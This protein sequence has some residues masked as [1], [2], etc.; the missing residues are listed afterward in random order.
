MWHFRK[1]SKGEDSVDPIHGEFFASEEIGGL[2]EILVR[3]SIQNSLDARVDKHQG[4]AKVII[5]YKHS[6]HTFEDL[7]GDGMPFAGLDTHVKSS[8]SGL[9]HE[10]LPK[11]E[12]IVDYLVIEDFGTRGLNGDPGYND[13]ERPVELDELGTY[14]FFFFWRN[15]GRSGKTDG[16]GSWGLGKHVFP[17][18]SRINSYFGLTRRTN[19]DAC[20]LMG[21]SILKIHHNEGHKFAPYGYYGQLEDNDFFSLPFK[22]VAQI[23]SFRGVFDI[24]RKDEA[25]LS[26]IVPFPRKDLLDPKLLVDSVLRDYFYPVIQG[27]LKVS[28]CYEGRAD[29]IIEASSIRSI[30]TEYLADDE[31]LLKTIDL[32]A[33]RSKLDKGSIFKI[34]NPD[35]GVA[36]S[37]ESISISE[38]MITELRESVYNEGKVAL[39][40]PVRVKELEGEPKLGSFNISF[41]LTDIAKSVPAKYIREGIDVKNA[42]RAKLDSGCIALVE[43]HDEALGKLLRVSE[44]PA[45]DRWEQ[46]NNENLVTLYDRGSKTI[47]FV[48]SAPY[49]VWRQITKKNIERNRDLLRDIFHLDINDIPSGSKPKT[50]DK[51]KKKNREEEFDPPRPGI[52]MVRTDKLQGPV[53]GFVVAPSDD[54]THTP[55]TIQIKIAYRVS[56]SARFNKYSPLDFSLSRKPIKIKLVGSKV[57]SCHENEMMVKVKKKKFRVEVTGFDPNRDLIVQVIP[58]REEG[59]DD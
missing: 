50:G 16:I 51:V 1:M 39:Q 4:E 28:L 10:G 52:R 31:M 15:I 44:P 12:E 27:Q 13:S 29:I 6:A 53:S 59:E 40:V 48:K 11:S 35:M 17:A 32:A 30:A 45:H 41:A 7:L 34:P 57:L 20:L 49:E 18:A 38:E 3:E 22:D 24:Q 47:G 26:V 21:K 33:W 5:T 2:G 36:P 37:I 23:E 46:R 55:E 25:G 9:T 14:D 58:K 43:V 19:D 8:N 54:A 42:N 56:S